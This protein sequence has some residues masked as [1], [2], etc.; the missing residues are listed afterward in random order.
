MR[1]A[2]ILMAVLAMCGLVACGDDAFDNDAKTDVSCT[3]VECN[4][5]VVDVFSRHHRTFQ[6]C[7]WECADYRGR[8]NDFVQLTFVRHANSCWKLT[9]EFIAE[10]NCF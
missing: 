3:Q 1:M 10:G 9:D 4:A 2:R 5:D 6:V 8:H 7:T